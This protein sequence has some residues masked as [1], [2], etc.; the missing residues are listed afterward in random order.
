M[1]TSAALSAMILVADA[2]A[3]SE[4]R[5]QTVCLDTRDQHF[6]VLPTEEYAAVLEGKDPPFVAAVVTTYPDGRV[7][8]YRPLH[9]LP[10][11]VPDVP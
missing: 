10:K 4:G 7:D 11:E 5:P 9:S 1:R 3:Q 6:T 2:A 8:L